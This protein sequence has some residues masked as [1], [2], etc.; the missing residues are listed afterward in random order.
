MVGIRNLNLK[1]TQI[2]YN[3]LWF[4]DIVFYKPHDCKS[5]CIDK[6]DLMF[7]ALAVTG[8]VSYLVTDGKDLLKI[9]A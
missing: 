4:L 9:K 6:N 7:L 5:A 1:I 2:S 8:Y 3:K